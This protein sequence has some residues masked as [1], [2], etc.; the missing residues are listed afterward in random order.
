[1]VESSFPIFLSANFVNQ[2]VDLTTFTKAVP[3]EY[4]LLGLVLFIPDGSHS[5]LIPNVHFPCRKDYYKVY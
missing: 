2:S 1:M 4:S 5:I 3:V